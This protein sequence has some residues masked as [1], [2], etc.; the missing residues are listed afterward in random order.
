MS[1]ADVVEFEQTEAHCEP[2]ETS[3]AF[4]VAT[5]HRAV[6]TSLVMGFA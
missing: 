5:R 4:T 2:G 1:L 3:I 6:K